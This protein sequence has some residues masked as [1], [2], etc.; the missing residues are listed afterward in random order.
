MQKVYFIYKVVNIN[1]IGAAM[2]AHLICFYLSFGL[3]GSVLFSAC[4]SKDFSGSL[5]QKSE[6]Q[7]KV[8]KFKM[9]SP[10][11]AF[12]VAVVDHDK[13]QLAAAGNRKMGDPTQVTTDDYWHI[14]SMTK[15]MTAL[16]LAVMIEEKSVTLNTTFQEVFPEFRLNSDLSKLPL[17]RFLTHTAGVDDD[18]L[19]AD[20]KMRK[21]FLKGGDR[22]EHSRQRLVQKFLTKSS[23]HPQLI[24]RYSN[25][26]Y[27]LVGALLEKISG[28]SWEQLITEKIFLPLHMNNCGFGPTTLKIGLPPDQPWGHRRTAKNQ[29]DSVTPG[30]AADNPPILGPAGTVHCSLSDLAKYVRFHLNQMEGKQT[31]LNLHD[32][33]FLYDDPYGVGYTSGGFVIEKRSEWSKGLLFWHNG[34]NTMNFSLMILAPKVDMAIVVTTNF[35]EHSEATES[36][37]QLVKSIR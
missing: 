17:T 16:L 12:G 3:L 31:E 25:L 34:S 9:V 2:R 19:F 35:G 26:D 23:L 10:L 15:S 30:P 37:N 28:K 22:L 20:L 8:E 13:V 33:T 1:P 21:L 32:F 24:Y 4:A 7:L 18:W 5:A 6:L 11:P 29:I 14:G 27:M 36:L